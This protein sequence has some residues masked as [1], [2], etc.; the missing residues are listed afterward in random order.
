MSKDSRQHHSE[1]DFEPII[2]GW[3]IHRIDTDCRE[4]YLQIATG[5]WCPD[6]Y[7]TLFPVQSAAKIYAD[8]FGYEVGVDVEIVRFQF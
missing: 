8:E 7:A 4:R 2:E 5:Q 1:R 3:L 6:V